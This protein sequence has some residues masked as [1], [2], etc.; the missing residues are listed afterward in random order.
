M[1]A[2]TIFNSPLEVGL[3][4][5]YLLKVSYP[6]KCSLDRL[7]YLD[8]LTIYTK[9]STVSSQSLHPEYPLRAIELFARREPIKKGLLLM[10]SK[11]LIHIHCE[12]S[13]FSYSANVNTDWFINS[14]SDEYSINLLNKAILVKE[15]FGEFSDVELKKFIDSNIKSWGREFIHFFPIE[16]EV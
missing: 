1:N 9:D 8:Y 14:F 11:G 10:A 2:F 12:E 3:R 7:I 5:L 6:S 4:S 16:N 13:G 15:K